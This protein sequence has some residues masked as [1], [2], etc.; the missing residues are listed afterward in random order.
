MLGIF[1]KRAKS[2][3]QYSQHLGRIYRENMISQDK[4]E[5]VFSFDINGF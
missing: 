4:L 1:G 5:N 2:S 3:Q